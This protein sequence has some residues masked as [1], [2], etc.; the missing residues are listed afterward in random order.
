MKYEIYQLKEDTMEQVKLRFMASDQAAALGG[1]HRENYRLVYEGNVETRKDAQQTL[2]GLFRI[3]CRCTVQKVRA[4][5]YPATDSNEAMKAGDKATEGKYAEMFRFNPGKQRA[6]YPAYNSYTIKKCATCK[7]NE[8]ELAK[9]PSNELC[10]A[11]PI[12]RECAGDISKSQAAI[13]RKHYLREMQP[14]LKK[15]VVLEIGGVK[16][17]IGFTKEGNKHLYSDT[18]GRSSV[19]KPDDLAHL[20]NVLKQSVYV[21][22][23]DR[24]SHARKDKVKRFFYLKGDING[25]TVYLNVA[26]AEFENRDGK[27]KYDRF[28]Y[29]VTDKIKSE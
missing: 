5:K 12:I 7:K 27:K 1:I 6:A 23:S 4:A 26:E 13:E 17:S 18:F 19:L 20:D 21:S 11:C 2:D 25:K 14:L 29:S 24:L 16:K 22:T 8:L 9:I 10:A 15:K 3:N 28:L